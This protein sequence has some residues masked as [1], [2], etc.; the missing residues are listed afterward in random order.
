MAAR[1]CC[2]G[3]CLLFC[4]CWAR[5]QAHAQQAHAHMHTRT[6]SHTHTHNA[7]A[8]Q[9]SCRT[10]CWRT[11][12]GWTARLQNLRLLAPGPCHTCSQGRRHLRLCPLV[13]RRHPLALRR[14]QLLRRPV[15]LYRRARPALRHQRSRRSPRQTRGPPL[16]RL[17][18]RR[19]ALRAAATRRHGGGWRPRRH[20][21]RP[22]LRW[23]PRAGAETV[24]QMPPVYMCCTCCPALMRA[25]V[26]LIAPPPVCKSSPSTLHVAAQYVQRF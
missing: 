19:R 4:C 26:L 23:S 15:S 13:L 18:R 9:A 6:F 3:T 17:L 24:E 21:W 20:R 12:R 10:G 2:L 16:L 22:L 5:L 1:A 7:S 25:C 8:T 14:L 11:P